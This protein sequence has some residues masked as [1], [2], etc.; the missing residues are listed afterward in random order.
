MHLEIGAVGDCE[1][2]EKKRLTILS[3]KHLQNISLG[4]LI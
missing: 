3:S 2:L 4:R 1:V